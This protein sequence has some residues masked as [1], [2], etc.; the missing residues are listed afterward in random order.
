[1]A[2]NRNKPCGDCVTEEDDVASKA[3]KDFHHD[4][5]PSVLLLP[6]GRDTGRGGTKV[7]LSM[8]KRSIS[9]TKTAMD[10]SDWV[11]VRLAAKNSPNSAK[12]GKAYGSRLGKQ[13]LVHGSC[14]ASLTS[15]RLAVFVHKL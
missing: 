12:S 7:V 11:K 4:D 14:D 10:W 15:V 1:M 6:V 9:L 3:A 13:K 5:D 8:R 2:G